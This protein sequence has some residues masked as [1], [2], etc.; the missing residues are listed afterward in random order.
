MHKKSLFV[1]SILATFVFFGCSEDSSDNSECSNNN[2]PTCFS[3]DFT[4]ICQNG[5]YEYH[6][7]MYGCNAQTGTCNPR[8]TSCVTTGCPAGKTCNIQTGLCDT[9][10]A[11][12]CETANYPQ[13]EGNNKITCEGGQ[14]KSEPCGTDET[15][16]SG[17]CQPQK[18]TQCNEADYPQ[19]DGNNKLTCESGQIKTEPCGQNETC[20]AGRCLP[21]EQTQCNAADYPQCDGN[22]KLTCENGQ[23]KTAP[24]GQDETCNGGVCQ[25]NAQVQ[26]DEVEYPQCDGNNKLTC[27]NG[28]IKSEPCG[29]NKTCESGS[30]V[31][32]Q[33][34]CIDDDYPMCDQMNNVLTCEAGQ[35]RSTPCGDDKT[36]TQ[37]ICEEITQC[38]EAD[39]PK[40]DDKINAALSCVAGKIKTRKCLADETCQEGECVAKP[41]E[42]EATTCRDGL[43]AVCNAQ[44]TWDLFAC[45]ANEICVSGECVERGA[46]PEITECP[47]L[48][49]VSGATCS[50]V[51]NGTGKKLVLQGDV[52]GLEKTWKSGS[53]VIE[54]D[55]ITYVGCTP[56]T[57][58]AIVIS[59]PDSVISPAFINGH[60]HTTFSNGAPQKWGDERFDH[61]NDWRKGKNGHTKLPSDQTSTNNGNSVVEVRALMSGTT[62]IFGSGSA[63]GLARNLDVKSSTIGGVTSIYQTFPLNDTDGVTKESGCDYNYHDT[64]TAFNATCPYGPHIAEGINQSAANEMRCLSGEGSKSRDI[65][66]P[67]VAIIHGIGATT[68]QIKKMADNQ[69]KLIWS[70]RTNISLYGDTAQAPLYDKMGVT[71]GLGTDWIYSGSATMLRELQ[72]VDYLNQNHYSLYFSDYEIWKMP[73]W[74]NAIAFG[75]DKYL[76]QIAVGYTADIVMFKKTATKDLYRA[77]IDAQNEDVLLVTMNGNRVYG[78]ANIMDSGSSVKVCKTDKKFD[79]AITKAKKEIT[80]FSVIENAAAYDVFF[81]DETPKNE[82]SCV[83]ARTRAEDT[84]KQTTTLYNGDYTA[85]DDADGDGIKDN[86][87]NCPTI[88]NPIRPMDT[89]RKQVDTDGDGQGD[90]CDPFPL[91]AAN[92]ETCTSPIVVVDKDTDKDGIIDD[93][94]NCP[95]VVNPDQKDTDNDGIGDACDTCPNGNDSCSN[96]EFTLDFSCTN[97]KSGTGYAA[98]YTETIDNANVSVVG[99]I[100]KYQ[101]LQG[102]TLTGSTDRNTRIDVTNLNGIGTITL[103]YI[104]YNP[105]GGKGILNIV[106]G[107]FSDQLIHTYDKNNIE[108]VTTMPFVIN[109]KNATSFSLVPEPGGT[110]ANDNR[111]HIT[112]VTWTSFE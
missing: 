29:Q 8:A 18:Q 106:A 79:F 95:T 31:D 111:I 50:K 83:P 3:E 57:T 33:P 71:I 39:Y 108:E 72:C 16:I 42:P 26:C 11:P 99:N 28:Q 62:S 27:E 85:S 53:V 94:D 55:K 40:C 56:D 100:Q 44:E 52:L 4:Q 89:N 22:N 80:D 77:V 6:P 64:V 38:D 24:C 23:I 97:C 35:I 7:C 93:E 54:G 45:K 87:D 51:K 69:V 86:V 92:D 21:Q 9:Q 30:C 17:V 10:S 46:A 12:A 59:C 73:T 58:N 96:T 76:G 48:P 14:I 19:C 37:G 60:E 109:D 66:K 49:A 98:T 112:K 65:F 47:A 13:C 90:I 101:T 63:P 102:A 32:I 81:C 82:P 88:F 110:S 67:N 78:D 2:P 43:K 25:K 84:T 61:R 15:C 104:S 68:N 41:C 1:A 70:P 74:N 36:C 105:T 75:I 34:A 107:S 103:S 20:L 91:C 5:K